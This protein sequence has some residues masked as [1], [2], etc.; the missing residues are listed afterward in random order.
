MSGYWTETQVAAFM[1][2][3]RIPL[4]LAVQDA[5]GCPLVMSLWYLYDD[6]AIWCATNAKAYVLRRL[7]NEPNCGFEI[8]GDTPPYRGVRGKGQANLY[9]EHGAE[10]LKRLLVRY[11]VSPDSKLAAS[12]LSKIDQE[13][14]I[15][16]DLGRITSWDFSQRMKGAIG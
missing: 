13:V 4:R 16:I 14:A 12:L 11:G 8:A 10:I 5:M 6:G 1:D 9:P 15:R 7:R 2:E 3:S